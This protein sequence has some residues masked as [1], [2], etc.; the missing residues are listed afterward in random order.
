M[1][2]PVS[3]PPNAIAYSTG[4]VTSSQMAR[5]GIIMGIV[6]LVLGYTLLFFLGGIGY[7]A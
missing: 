6:S 1:A 3:T 4:L 5:A 2:L 7:F